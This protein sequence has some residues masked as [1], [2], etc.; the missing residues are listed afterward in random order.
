MSRLWKHATKTKTNH[1]IPL[2][3]ILRNPSCLQDIFKRHHN[4]FL[5]QLQLQ[6]YYC[7][8]SAWM[9]FLAYSSTWMKRKHIILCVNRKFCFLLCGS[10]IIVFIVL[11]HKA[12]D[13]NF[14]S[15]VQ[16]KR[17]LYCCFCWDSHVLWP[18]IWSVIISVR[19]RRKRLGCKV[20]Q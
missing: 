1:T 14:V 20:I 7:I 18:S 17:V 5:P 15:E 12:N 8:P 4:H 9:L 11:S 19:I 6:H 13:M 10:H 16:I 3:F 2:I